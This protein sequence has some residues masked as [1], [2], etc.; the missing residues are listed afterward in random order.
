MFLA[1]PVSLPAAFR[2]SLLMVSELGPLSFPTPKPTSICKPRF[3]A[4]LKIEEPPNSNHPC[5]FLGGRSMPL[6]VVVILLL[7]FG[8]D[9]VDQT[10]HPIPYIRILPRCHSQNSQYNLTS[11]AP[12][13]NP[14]KA[15]S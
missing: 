12:N 1:A 15:L 13:Q 5:I 8:G 7:C 2:V 10:S 4:L 9:R 11:G 3:L 14:S 6:F